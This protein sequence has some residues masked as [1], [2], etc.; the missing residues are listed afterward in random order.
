[1]PG[2]PI[3]L[4]SSFFRAGQVLPTDR[5]RGVFQPSLDRSVDL[6]ERGGWVH[7]FPEGYVNMSRQAR[8]RRFKWG[9]ARMLL[10]AGSRSPAAVAPRA[11]AQVEQQQLRPLIIPIWISGLDAMMPEPRGIP[12]WLPRPGANVTITIGAPVNDAVEPVLDRML[13]YID[14]GKSEKSEGGK[15][16]EIDDTPS[17]AVTVGGDVST[18]AEELA[19]ALAE[20]PHLAPQYPIPS[21]ALFSP[22]TPLKPPSGGV[23]W[24]VP[25]PESRSAHAVSGGLD[26]ER[27]RLARSLVAAELRAHLVMLGEESGMDM[28]LAHRLMPDAS[29]V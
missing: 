23:P 21:S 10:E 29:E 15:L 8:V 11:K 17:E 13:R 20:V 2:A 12:R 14:D 1:M 26:S 28:R 3:S 18:Q 27:A 7:I 6:L 19:R 16:H 9:I 5:G 25:L 4:F 22:R 24:P